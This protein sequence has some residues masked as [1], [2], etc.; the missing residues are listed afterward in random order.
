MLTSDSCTYMNESARGEK[1]V[2]RQSCGPV[3]LGCH[4]IKSSGMGETAVPPASILQLDEHSHPTPVMNDTFQ[5][6][7][8][9]NTCQA[10]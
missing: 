6:S 1:H 3:H 4:C 8:R 9:T 2:Y 10:G 7:C 5:Q